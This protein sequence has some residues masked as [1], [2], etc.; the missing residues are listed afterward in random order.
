MATCP[1][2]SVSRMRPVH[3]V[4][5]DARLLARVGLGLHAQVVDR[6]RQERH[7]DAL[8][9]GEE[10]VELPLGRERGDLLGEVEE[11]V[12]GVAHGAHHDDHVV[13]RSLGFGDPLRDALYAACVPDRGSTVLLHDEC[14]A[15]CLL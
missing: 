7:G 12:G 2:F 1:L 10:D 9:R 8:A 3:G 6:H 11:L 13:A 15:A 4:G 14:H 5:D